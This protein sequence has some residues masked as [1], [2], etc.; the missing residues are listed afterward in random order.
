[1]LHGLPSFIAFHILKDT[2]IQFTLEKILDDDSLQFTL[3]TP[4]EPCRSSGLL[5]VE[6]RFVN[7]VQVSTLSKPGSWRSSSRHTWMGLPRHR[8]TTES[9]AG[10][11]CELGTVIK[12]SRSCWE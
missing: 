11:A 5:R 6:G 10:F 4:E 12:S 8:Q 3:L 1:M 2:T 7:S 9:C